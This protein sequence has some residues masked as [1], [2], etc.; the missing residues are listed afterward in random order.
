MWRLQGP[1]DDD[2]QAENSEA[3]TAMALLAFQG[4]GYTSESSKSDS[5]TRVVTRRWHG[6]LHSQQPDGRFYANLI[7]ESHQLYT[8]AP[9]TIAVCELYG[10]THD[11]TYLDAAQS[12]VDYCVQIQTREGGWRYQPGTDS[13]M[14]VTGWFAM[15]LQSARMAGI[16]VPSSAFERIGSFLDT[17]ERKNGSQ[18]AY[19]PQDG[20][21][22]PLTAE[23]LLTRQYLGWQRSDPRLRA[24]VELLRDR[25]AVNARSRTSPLRLV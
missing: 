17:V 12:A 7:P 19:R 9:C 11:Q 24:G 1:Y 2:S 16:E 23:G 13:D 5:F 10:M 3:A 21:T 15:A 6:L 4:A 18:Y 20:A 8:Q 14:S 25:G 22:L